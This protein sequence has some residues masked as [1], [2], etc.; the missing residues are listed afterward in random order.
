MSGE[1]TEEPTTKKKQDARKKGQV[2]VSKD[3]Q[4]VIKLSAFYLFFFWISGEF[5]DDLAQLINL[6]SA[7]A[8][9]ANHTNGQEILD[10]AVQVLM[11]MI[12]P[13]AMVCAIAG[14]IA[15]VMQ[16]GLMPSPES[17]TP[18]FKKFDAVGTIK[19]MLSK[20][21]FM[22]LLMSV[23]K[24]AILVLVGYLVFMDSISA[25]LLS[26]RVGVTQFF[27]VLVLVLERIVLYSLSVFV[28][29]AVIDWTME[30]AHLTKQL[31]MSLQ[32]IKDEYKQREGDPR[33]KQKR[34]QTHRNLLS[35]SLSKV[36]TAKAVVTN[37]T[38]I[39]VALDYQPGK[40]DLPFV[41]CMGEDDEA[42]LI[43]NE[44]RKHGVPIISS[45]K[46]ARMIYQDCEEEEYI[47]KQHLELAAEVFRTVMEMQSQQQKPN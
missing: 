38:H 34:K 19:N 9:Q 31:R 39:A 1:K 2:A 46:L 29:I 16:I 13:I 12:V 26:Y 43:R 44:A 30:K 47:Q 37:P 4:I 6:I 22:Q 24:V 7:T 23:V 35:A 45:V 5:V 8:F 21:S 32:D 28:I 41:L 42:A 25:I 11:L 18:S 33:L 10:M 17:A 15:T 36:G 40:H 14:F 20:K 27:D 3:G